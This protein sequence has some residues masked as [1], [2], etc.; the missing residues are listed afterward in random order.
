MLFGALTVVSREWGGFAF[1][2]KNAV[3]DVVPYTAAF[4]YVAGGLLIQVPRTVRLGAAI[5]S[6]AFALSALL[7]AG[8]VVLRFAEPGIWDG[9]F[10]RLGI[11]AGA[12][13]VFERTSRAP[14]ARL[15][16]A[17]RTLFGICVVSYTLAQ[18]LFLHATATLVPTWIPPGQTFWAV[19][20]TVAFALAAI[21]FLTG[22]GTLLAARLLAL[23]VLIFGVTIWIPKTVA[24]PSSLFVWSELGWTFAI[25][26]TAWIVAPTRC[27][28][29]TCRPRQQSRAY[30]VS[31]DRP[32]K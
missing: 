26:A 23:M 18:A 13:I 9:L 14:D 25:A 3:D 2:A 32:A 8:A 30:A 15:L 10:E 20:T 11:F 27:E 4:V 21:A 17:A 16:G 19:T 12:F 5:M 24:A 22:L 31:D 1:H 7:Y 28:S 6:I 29:V